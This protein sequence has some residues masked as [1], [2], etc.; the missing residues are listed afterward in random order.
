[1]K[2]GGVVSALACALALAGVF[3]LAG[4]STR[5]KAERK[6]PFLSVRRQEGAAVAHPELLPESMALAL[7]GLPA[8]EMTRLREGLA[9]STEAAVRRAAP[10][11]FDLE[12]AGDD[13]GTTPGPLRQAT[14]DLPALT[15]AVNVLGAPWRAPGISV[16][17][18]SACAVASSDCVPLFVPAVSTASSNSALSQLTT[19]APV[20]PIS[21]IAPGKPLP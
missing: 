7:G 3:G 12:S 15:A 21:D 20:V 17:L 6:G 13:A 11:L 19:A 8:G 10:A 18:G 4:C 16:E 5:A 1:M 14:P 9:E 2:R